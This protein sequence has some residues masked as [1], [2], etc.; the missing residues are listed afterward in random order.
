MKQKFENI[1][2]AYVE[3]FLRKHNFFYEENGEYSDYEWV[4]DEVGGILCVADYYISFDDIRRDIDECV[5]KKL[6]F[7]YYDYVLE[8]DKRINY[9]SYLMGAR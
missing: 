1:C 2:H 6:Y 5:N 9:K 7:E 8:N 3:S 4:G